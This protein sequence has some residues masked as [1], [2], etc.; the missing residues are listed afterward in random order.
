MKNIESKIKAN[1]VRNLE[2]CLKHHGIEI[3]SLK[4]G[5]IEYIQNI[6]KNEAYFIILKKYCYKE[7][8][9]YDMKDKNCNIICKLVPA[10]EYLIQRIIKESKNEKR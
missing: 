3:N 6:S 10:Q 5:D 2:I 1:L 4:K 9:E 8:I 7:V